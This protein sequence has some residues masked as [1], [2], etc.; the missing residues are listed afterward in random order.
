MRLHRL[1]M[2]AAALLALTGC[3]SAIVEATISNRTAA[4][5]PLI[6]VDYPSASF[7]TENLAPGKDFHYRFKI[8]G[9]G[10][11]KVVYTDQSQHEQHNDGPTL[12][13][14]DEGHITVLFAQDGIHWQW[15]PKKR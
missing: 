1:L 12:R 13:E 4:P 14:G 3:H 7:G 8:L 11:T 15:A 10:P 2:P 6:E 9:D 5:I